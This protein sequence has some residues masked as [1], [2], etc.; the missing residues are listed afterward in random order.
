VDFLLELL[1]QLVVE[2]VGELLLE[3]GAHGLVGVAHSARGRRVTGTLL[4][5][6]AGF[7]WG[8]HLSGGDHWPRLLWV[9]LVLAAAALTLAMG[10]PAALPKAD[11]QVQWR[12]VLQPPWLWS[13]VR[14]VDFALLNVAVAI[15]VVAG[16]GLHL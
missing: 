14:L 4:G 15:G 7:G 6:V 8:E 1:I 5:A 9:S 2:L 12:D 10:R 11:R 16:F 13:A 3:L